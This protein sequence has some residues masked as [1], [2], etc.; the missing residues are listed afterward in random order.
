MG[1][2][3]AIAGPKQET[4]YGSEY[5]ANGEEDGEDSLGREDGPVQY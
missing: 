5:N 1:A 3:Y 4:T 2:T